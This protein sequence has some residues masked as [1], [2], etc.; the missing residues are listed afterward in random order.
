M[1][2]LYSVRPILALLL[3]APLPATAQVSWERIADGLEAD[4]AITELA[5]DS[6][7]HIFALNQDGVLYRWEADSN[8]WGV[9]WD[10]VTSDPFE[11]AERALQ[12]NRAGIFVLVRRDVLLESGP[13]KW[14]G[15]GYTTWQSSN[16]GESWRPVGSIC[17]FSSNDSFVAIASASWYNHSFSSG[18]RSGSV[19]LSSDTGTTWGRTTDNVSKPALRDITIT[20]SGTI[21]TAGAD[22]SD[23]GPE[24]IAFF[25]STDLGA[26]WSRV[27][28]STW[29]YYEGNLLHYRNAVQRLATGPD[30]SIIAA[31]VPNNDRVLYRSTDNGDNWTLVLQRYIKVNHVLIPRSG[32]ILLE[33][34]TFAET[35]SLRSTDNG[36]TWTDV[37][38]GIHD[39]LIALD[40]DLYG[41]GSGHIWRSADAG[42]TWEKLSDAL[43]VEATSFTVTPSRHV[44]AGTRSSGVYRTTRS[45]TV[46]DPDPEAVSELEMRSTHTDGSINV[47]LMLPTAGHATVRLYDM[48]G[49]TVATLA[50]GWMAAGWNYVEYASERLPGGVYLIVLT[51]SRNHASQATVIQ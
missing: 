15:S 39:F 51:S 7:G 4:R 38:H 20:S 17:N 37:P 22:Q 28:D 11:I 45:L 18:V 8:R 6:T 21:F 43:P 1:K 24:N 5:V 48:L 34:G 41:L 3:I 42:E 2:L 16:G 19:S 26:S 36:D 25:R 29:N 27:G 12:V 9:K 14:M 32:V 23:G 10:S 13:E 30:G 49:R 47:S 44:Y 46:D 33:H 50:D 40:G 35:T 31:F